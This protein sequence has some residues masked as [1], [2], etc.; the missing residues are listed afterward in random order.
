MLGKDVHLEVV[1]AMQLQC[2]CCCC[3]GQLA[4]WLASCCPPPTMRLAAQQLAFMPLLML[5]STVMHAAAC[6]LHSHP[7]SLGA[8]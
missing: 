8:K 3:W 2:H 1:S 5:K 4:L 7:F 6:A